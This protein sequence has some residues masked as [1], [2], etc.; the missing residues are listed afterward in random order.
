MSENVR[1][2]TD[3]D[4]IDNWAAAEMLQLTGEDQLKPTPTRMLKRLLYTPE[5]LLLDIQNEAMF[6]RRSSIFQGPS[7]LVSML[8]FGKTIRSM[9]S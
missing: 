8:V 9:P 2:K 3:S 6:E 7:F 1:L 4:V 5:N